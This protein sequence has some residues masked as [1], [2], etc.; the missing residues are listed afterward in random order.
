MDSTVILRTSEL[1]EG[2]IVLE[3]GMRL[4][5]D[6]PIEVSKN[7]PEV[8]PRW[9]G[10]D[11]GDGHTRWT[12]ALLLNRDEVPY[13]LVPF[14]WTADWKRNTRYDGVPHDGQHRWVVQG[15]DRASWR[16][17]RG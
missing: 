6:Q 16:V 9:E 4:L 1:R 8:L 11:V 14:S 10:E 12:R 7:H 3:H 17:E 5:I 2:D 15:N 13:D